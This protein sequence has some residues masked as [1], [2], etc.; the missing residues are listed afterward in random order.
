MTSGT[1]VV[2]VV[3]K[4]A[5]KQAAAF[6]E[7]KIGRAALATYAELSGLADRLA[8]WEYDKLAPDAAGIID[9]AAQLKTGVDRRAHDAGKSAMFGNAS[10][11]ELAHVLSMWIM[12]L[13]PARRDDTLAWIRNGNGRGAK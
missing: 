2:D 8:P 6:E 10:A 11:L 7:R 13:P 1:V 9:M 3:D 4:S 12:R 5:E